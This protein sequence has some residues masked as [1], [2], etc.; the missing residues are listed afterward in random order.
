MDL[1]LLEFDADDHA[2]VEEA[3]ALIDA[4][5]AADSPSSPSSSSSSPSVNLHP[6]SRS[7]LKKRRRSAAVDAARRQRKKQERIAL[8]SEAN[9]LE[10][11]LQLLRGGAS[12]ALISKLSEAEA[13]S[14]EWYSNAID[15]VRRL[16]DAT[17]LN[18]RL[19]SALSRQSE[20]LNAVRIALSQ[21]QPIQVS[22]L[23]SLSY[24][25]NPLTGRAC[26]MAAGWP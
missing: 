12:T 10:G 15:Q 18:W 7:S 3:L 17:D 1:E 9:E 21:P 25:P 14:G 22:V 16:A 23:C 26:G 20:L 5:E 24:R 8:Q 19:R 13:K 4:L 11:I 6:K 2:V